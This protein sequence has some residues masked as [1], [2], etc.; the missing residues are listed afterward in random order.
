VLD[1][2]QRFYPA[3]IDNASVLSF[4]ALE[5]RVRRMGK[6]ES[7]QT[8]R[9]S[10]TRFKLFVPACWT[11]EVDP[12]Y[13][14]YWSDREVVV[15]LELLLLQERGGTKAF[16]NI[17]QAADL[18]VADLILG[19]RPDFRLYGNGGRRTLPRS[20]RSRQ[21]PSAPLGRF[22]SRDGDRRMSLRSGR[23]LVRANANQERSTNLYRVHDGYAEGRAESS[24]WNSGN[25]SRC[26]KTF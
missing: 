3:A 25:P 17:G 6:A 15:F 22:Q 19:C 14:G 2:E 16:V 24:D 4:G 26:N 13:L 5:P 20:H 18:Q 10:S 21:S 12:S 1:Q 9:S 8:N 23:T 7:R 11:H